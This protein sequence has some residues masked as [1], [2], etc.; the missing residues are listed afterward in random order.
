[1][2]M[3]ENTAEVFTAFSMFQGEV[4]DVI[5]N[6]ASYKGKYAGLDQVVQ[7]RKLMSKYGLSFTQLPG[8][9]TIFPRK[10]YKQPEKSPMVINHKDKDKDKDNEVVGVLQLE[11]AV[12][13]KSGQ[14]FSKTMSM[15]F[16]KCPNGISESQHIGMVISYMRRY[17]LLSMLGLA[18]EDDDAAL[19]QKQNYP[20]RQSQPAAQPP[21][22]NK[23]PRGALELAK[24][25]SELK[26]LMLKHAIGEDVVEKW[27]EHYEVDS[28]YDISFESMLKLIGS[29]KYKYG[30][31]KNV[32]ESEE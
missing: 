9:I 14:W 3:S 18:Q 5:R 15:K 29:I 11:N 4:E 22:S 30:E 25:H 6:T 26:E 8:K 7:A 27:R 32:K 17:G 12:F 31:F 16:G 23:P 24:L 21:V 20:A 19:P 2:K 10:Q 28:I 1:M 13:H